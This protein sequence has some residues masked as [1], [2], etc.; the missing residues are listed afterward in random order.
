[1]LI[2]SAKLRHPDSIQRI[3]NLLSRALEQKLSNMHQLGL[4]WSHS[5]CGFQWPILSRSHPE[6]KDGAISPILSHLY[7]PRIQCDIVF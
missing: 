2:V 3:Y 7:S 4:H 6:D 1:M 5:S